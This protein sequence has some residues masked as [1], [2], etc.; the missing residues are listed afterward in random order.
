MILKSKRPIVLPENY[1]YCT[2]TME[3]VMSP[4][5]LCDFNKMM[6]NHYRDVLVKDGDEV[7]V[8]VRKMC[9]EGMAR[10]ARNQ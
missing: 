5:Q 8:E 2:R 3:G 4:E 6:F 7:N 1:I 9:M 10:H